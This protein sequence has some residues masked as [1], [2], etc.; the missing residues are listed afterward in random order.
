MCVAGGVVLAA[1]LDCLVAGWVLVAVP[2]HWGQ[3]AFTRSCSHLVTPS[4]SWLLRGAYGVL[5]RLAVVAGATGAGWTLA[6]GLRG[7]SFSFDA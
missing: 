7:R 4:S 6:G 3:M 1:L 5:G 2:L